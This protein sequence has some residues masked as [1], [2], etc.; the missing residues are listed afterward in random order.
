[1]KGF[2]RKLGSQLNLTNVLLATALVVANL[3]TWVSMLSN[4]AE[5]YVVDPIRDQEIVDLLEYIRSGKH[6]GETWQVTL[7]ELEAEQTITW[8][9]HRWPQIP[10]AHPDVEITPDYIF[11]AGD[12]TIAGLRVHVSGKARITLQDGLPVVDILEL[13]LPLP[14]PIRRALERE[15]QAQLR[16]AD[17]LPVRFTS[18]E[19]RDGEVTVHGVIR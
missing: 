8:Y 18:A 1:M 16:R 7:T 14:G 10:F 12:A 11:G 9:L 5:P 4:A 3:F 17:L 2:L 13:S 15:I 19:W 6:G